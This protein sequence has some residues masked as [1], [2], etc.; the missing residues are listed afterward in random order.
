[1]VPQDKALKMLFSRT[2]KMFSLPTLLIFLVV[3]FILVTITA[4]V[5]TAAG[6]FVPMMLIGATFGKILGQ[7]AKTFYPT[8]D[9]SVFA[10]VGASA[11]MS[12]FS[13]TTISLCVLMMELTAS[14]QF[15]LP[16]MLAVMC[17]KWVG[18]ALSK[19]YY[20]EVLE[21][22]SITFLDP[23]PPRSTQL[24]RVIDIIN[25]DVVC[26]YEQDTLAR[27][28][29]VLQTTT[30]NGFPVVKKQSE[31]RQYTFSGFI[32]RKQLLILLSCKK[33]YER[34]VNLPSVLDYENYISMVNR[35]W[36]LAGIDLPTEE[37]RSLLMV[38][39]EPYMDK[40]HTIVQEQYSYSDAYRVFQM[41]GLR[42][43]TVVDDHFQVVGVI[44]RHDFLQHGMCDDAREE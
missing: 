10:L 42:H 44:T 17:A 32:L 19:S 8:A 12:G 41:L 24:K 38:N 43:M 6:L 13:R 16:V 29:E 37:S 20:H 1:M 34:G 27:V 31:E 11:M 15:L 5:S 4:G 14:T 40:S 26:L 35:K 21:S 36:S 18:D 33:Y 2:E 28:L 23:R 22:K 25:P 30:H 7:L 9:T 3:Y 39:V